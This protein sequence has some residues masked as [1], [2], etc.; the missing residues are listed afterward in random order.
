VDRRFTTFMVTALAVLVVNQIVYS[1]FFAPEPPPPGAKPAVADAKKQ[2]DEAAKKQP[3][4]GEDAPEVKAA[5]EE[6]VAGPPGWLREQ[7]NRREAPP[8]R[9]TGRRAS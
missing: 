3:A 9:S 1:L 7:P 4:E 8:P 5:P 2:P 6:P